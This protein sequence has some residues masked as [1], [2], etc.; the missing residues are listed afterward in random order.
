MKIL[1]TGATG[2]IGQYV[3]ESLKNK[4]IA[5]IDVKNIYNIENRGN[6]YIDIQ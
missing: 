4:G 3:A 2:F 1:L 6:I 5:L